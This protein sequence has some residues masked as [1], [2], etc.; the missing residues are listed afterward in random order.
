MEKASGPGKPRPPKTKIQ[1]HTFLE[2]TQG[3]LT[4]LPKVA[5]FLNA[6]LQMLVLSMRRHQ[7]PSTNYH[8]T[9]IINHAPP[10]TSCSASALLLRPR[11]LQA[12][13]VKYFT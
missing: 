10:P 9:C 4:I 2:S 5:L 7:L 3:P 11:L 1:R 13:E 12:S 8:N 6:L